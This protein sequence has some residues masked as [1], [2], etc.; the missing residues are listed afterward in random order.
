M[1]AGSRKSKKKLE[2]EKAIQEALE[3]A[4]AAEQAQK[5]KEEQEERERQAA[6]ALAQKIA[7]IVY[8]DPLKEIVCWPVKVTE[9]YLGKRNIQK[10]RDFEQFTN[11]KVLWLNGNQVG[12]WFIRWL[13]ADWGAGKPEL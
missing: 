7:S 1:P 6:I 3:A 13:F 10:L 8:S 11:L 4:R 2:E 5:E 9:L 12:A